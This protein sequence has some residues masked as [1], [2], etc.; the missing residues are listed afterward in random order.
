[1]NLHWKIQHQWHWPHA[2]SGSWDS[3]DS[4]VTTQLFKWLDNLC[5]IPLVPLFAASNPTLEPKLTFP[6]H[7]HVGFFCPGIY[8]PEREANK[9][10][11]FPKSRTVKSVPSNFHKVMLSSPTRHKFILYNIHIFG[12]WLKEWNRLCLQD[13]HKTANGVWYSNRPFFWE[14]QENR[15]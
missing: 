7:R 9:L 6:I 8:R 12:S 15:K 10:F 13:R 11:L 5:S 2:V 4:I 1:V 14:L 3:L